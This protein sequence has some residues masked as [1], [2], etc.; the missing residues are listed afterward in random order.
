MNT[1]TLVTVITPVH[2]AA[3]YLPA[4]IQSMRNQS[5]QDF[6]HIIIDDASTD[7]SWSIIA[8]FA[9]KDARIK[10]I[11]N[12]HKNS[13]SVVRNQALELAQGKYIAK[14]DADDVSAPHRLQTQV[15]YLEQSPQIVLCG[16]GVQYFS[17]DQD[18]STW[19]LKV[20]S[21]EIKCQLLFSNCLANSTVMIR[22]AAID[23]YH[24][25]Y[26]SDF[27]FSEDYGLW[28]ALAQRGGVA[29]I[30]QILTNVRQHSQKVS[31]KFTTTQRENAQKVQALL[32]QD[33]GI[34]LTLEELQLHFD[35]VNTASSLELPKLQQLSNWLLKLQTCNYATQ[36][37]PEPEFTQLLQQIWKKHTAG[38]THLGPAFFKVMQQNRLSM[39]HTLSA[40]QKIKFRVKCWLRK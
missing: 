26:Q 10:A 14:I 5:F 31:F 34:S 30:P 36:I 19:L 37:Y 12:P 39:Y 1:K 23:Q 7:N 29:I 4:C 27:D 40:Y 28:A 13:L 6:E 33:L 21:A 25:R 35:C 32:L 3:A 9:Q 20:T 38:R 2:N 15:D 18:L 8:D 24:L 22:K 16:A 17:E 11:K